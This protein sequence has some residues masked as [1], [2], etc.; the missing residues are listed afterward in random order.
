MRIFAE[1][2]PEEEIVHQLAGQCLVEKRGHHNPDQ[3]PWA[4]GMVHSGLHREQLEPLRSDG[5]DRDRVTWMGRQG[6]H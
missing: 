2:Y 1:A 4:A 3:G 6:H 5:P